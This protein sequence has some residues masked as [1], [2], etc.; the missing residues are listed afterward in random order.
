[1]QTLHPHL[2]FTSL[3][4]LSRLHTGDQRA[5]LRP[6]TSL[7]VSPT[8][9]PHNHLPSLSDGRSRTP[10]TPT[11]FTPPPPKTKTWSTTTT[12]VR[13]WCGNRRKR[14]QERE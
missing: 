11:S 1:M 5:E 2:S 6:A 3:E 7:L 12:T 10:V 14:E 9:H 4:P 13:W 8:H